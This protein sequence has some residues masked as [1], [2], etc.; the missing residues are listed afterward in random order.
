MNYSVFGKTMEDVEKHIDVQL[1][2]DKTKLNKLVAK[3]NFDRN[4]LF[5]ENL[6]AVHMKRTRVL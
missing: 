5:Y 4:V 1:V 6:V 3:P 2:T